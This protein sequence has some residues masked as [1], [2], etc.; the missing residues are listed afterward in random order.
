MVVPPGST[1]FGTAAEPAEPNRQNRTRQNLV[2]PNL[3]E[4][5]PE[6]PRRTPKNSAEP[7]TITE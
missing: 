2:E 1:R 7:T 6:E 3:E 4:Q 5:N